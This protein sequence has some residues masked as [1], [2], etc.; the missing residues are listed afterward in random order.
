MAAYI[1]YA[2]NLWFANYLLVLFVFSLALMAKP[3]TVTL[4][5][6]LLLLDYWPLARLQTW[7]KQQIF[8]LV[9][10]KIPLFLLSAALCVI[11]IAA[12]SSGDVLKLNEYF[13]FTVRLENA[14]VAYT[15]YIGKMLYP[16]Q[17]SV[18]YPHPCSSLPLW[19]SIVS[20]IVLAAVFIGVFCLGRRKPYLI[21]GW[22]WYLG[23]LVPVIGL[24]QAGD[25]AMADRYA[26]VPLIG[27]FIIIAWGI[28]DLLQSWKYRKIVLSLSAI[29]IISTLSI[30][31]WFQTSYWRSSQ[32]LF[33][34]ALRATTGNY[35]ACNNLG[36]TY[37]KLGRWE[38]EIKACNEA[39][40]IDP[41][42][43]DAHNNLGV[44]LGQLG[45]YPEAIQAFN[46][47]IRLNPNFA[48]CISASELRT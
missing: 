15:S 18:F 22:F 3:I 23:T 16:T 40:K 42:Y 36:V 48:E 2:K 47:A 26:Y 28:S 24:V 11:T 41:A 6:A 34:H 45:R 13:P 19:E 10:E 5:F 31:T 33:E 46:R 1:R 7:N 20:F 37:G 25:Q 4:P 8:R 44:A 30:C 12:Q 9:G 27:L 14:L 38:D 21:V 32:T 35:V 17:L 39:I 29:V 43:A